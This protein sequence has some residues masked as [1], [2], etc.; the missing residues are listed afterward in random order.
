MKY[1]PELIAKLYPKLLRKLSPE[2]KKYGIVGIA[3]TSAHYALMAILI[4][5]FWV[6]VVLATTIGAI[7]GALINYALN[8]SYTF[9][10]EVQHHKAMAAFWLIASI[11]WG[12]NA[13]IMA[14]NEYVVGFNV[15]FA[16]LTATTIVFFI[17]F[18]MNRRWTF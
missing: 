8:Y 12:V 13:G 16:Q 6:D 9:K 18:L 3:G 4:N 10:S 5:F 7:F 15:I 2:L 14:F 11:G 17:T 1:M